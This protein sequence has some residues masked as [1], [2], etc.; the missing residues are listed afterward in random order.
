MK[1]EDYYFMQ[2][3]INLAEKGRGYTFPNPLVGAVVVKEGKIIGEGYHAGYGRPHAESI[4][5]DSANERV[6]GATLYVTVEP[7][8]HFGKTPPCVDKIIKAGIKKVIIGIKDP[9]PLVNGKGI[10]K[11]R[12]NHIE[13]ITGVLENEI[14]RQNE[15]YIKFMKYSLPFVIVKSAVTLDAKIALSNGSSKWITGEKARVFAHQLRHESDAVLIGINTVLKDDPILDTRFVK[16][17]DPLKVILDFYLRI[18]LNAKLFKKGK[19]IIFT[20]IDYLD[21][22]FMNAE[23]V[24]VRG[25]DG[26]LSL[27]DVLKELAKRNVVQLLVE[28]G[29]KVISTFLKEKLVDKIILVINP[30]IIGRGINFTEHLNI[31]SLERR[32][33]LKDVRIRKIGEDIILEGYPVYW[34]N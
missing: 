34:N 18:P 33:K 1:F 16:G 7:C 9:N 5:I 32:I 10:E 3:A 24:R 6:E 26:L 4:A 12:Q 28:G 25:E 14:V 23:V 29:S 19:T 17:K 22:K 20:A 15:A 21:K 31:D 2:K 11:L 27:T 13:V 8:V 30:S